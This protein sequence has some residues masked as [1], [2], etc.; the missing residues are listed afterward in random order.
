MY[1]CRAYLGIE[2]VAI[3]PDPVQRLPL[4]L[5][6]C[7]ILFSCLRRAR[8]E[9]DNTRAETRFRL[10]PKRTSPFKSAGD[11]VQST[12]GSRGVRISV[13][14]AGYT[15]FRG[16]VRVLATYSIRQFPLQSPPP[17]VTV[18]H[19]IPNA[20][21]YY[22]FVRLCSDVQLISVLN[23]IRYVAWVLMLNIGPKLRFQLEDT[24]PTSY[25]AIICSRMV[26]SISL[27]LLDRE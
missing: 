6:L 27:T 9:P 23:K 18:C 17:C 19:H 22:L 16:R 3:I 14:N 1:G 15:T 12:A 4:E 11:S 20:V 26:S 25:T 21:Y 13:S 24:S 8:T 2:S 5:Q 10:S 7:S